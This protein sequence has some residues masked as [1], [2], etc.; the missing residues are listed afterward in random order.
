MVSEQEYIITLGTRIRQLR[1]ERE[2]S[3]QAL[4][5]ICNM[6][7]STIGRIERGNVSVTIKSIVKIANALEIEPL[8]IFTFKNSSK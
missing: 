3:Q 5:D 4:A 6:P 7:K 2:I 8:E 1:E